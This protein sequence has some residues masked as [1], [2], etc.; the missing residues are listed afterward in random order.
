[1]AAK[2]K[3]S[4]S[5]A[6]TSAGNSAPA[7]QWVYR[8]EPTAQT[9]ARTGSRPVA[10]KAVP[11]PRRTPARG[12]AQKVGRLLTPLALVHA[13]VMSPIVDRLLSWLRR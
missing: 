11:R 12:G 3:P 9:A 4:F 5:P 7:T 2:R 13:I 1:M 8:T 10:R 6:P